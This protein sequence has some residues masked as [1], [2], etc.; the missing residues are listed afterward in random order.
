[1]VTDASVFLKS[2]IV[3][4]PLLSDFVQG[5]DGELLRRKPSS[6]ADPRVFWPGSGQP[7]PV[8]IGMGTDYARLQK[9]R[10]LMG[11][12]DSLRWCCC[13]DEPCCFGSS[14]HQP[15]GPCLVSL[16]CSI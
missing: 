12:A 13:C 1:M 11:H 7:L 9:S 6:A 16:S 4:L 3:V 2:L 10:L 8:P 5:K 14:M 15:D